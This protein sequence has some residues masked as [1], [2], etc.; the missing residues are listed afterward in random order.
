MEIHADGLSIPST[1]SSSFPCLSEQNLKGA[2]M[3]KSMNKRASWEGA[4]I[5]FLIFSSAAAVAAQS[6]YTTIQVENGGTITGT[7]K[8]VGPVPKIPKLPVTKNP[9][10][11]DPESH[12]IR[13]LERLETSSDG[14][15][16]NTVVYLK[17]ITKGKEMDLPDARQHLDQKNCRYIP[18][19]ML[20]PQNGNLQIKSSDPILH[21]V[22]MSGAAANN[23]PFPL[24]NQYIPVTLRQKG[25]VN[26]KCNAGHVWMNAEILVVKHP[27]YAVT[28]GHGFFKLTDVPPGEYEIEAWHEGWRILAEEKVLDVAAQVEVHRPIYSDPVT[29]AKHV[30][31]KAGQTSETDFSISEK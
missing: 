27:Y 13:D 18:H 29:W 10:V 8:W 15:V 14:G 22:H 23:V 2:A 9:D 26:L 4:I 28:D 6:D 24:Q 31:V 30:S 21:T 3:S 19:I 17:D 5:L 16:A 12:K 25:V 7:V 20:V 11:C 1:P